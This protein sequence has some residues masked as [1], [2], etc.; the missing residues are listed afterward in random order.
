MFAKLAEDNENRAHICFICRC[1]RFS[2]ANNGFI[3]LSVRSPQAS[4]QLQSLEN[5]IGGIGVQGD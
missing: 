3:F 5:R 4:E 1:A 2:E